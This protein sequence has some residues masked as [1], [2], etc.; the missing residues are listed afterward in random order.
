MKFLKNIILLLLF[1]AVV[2]AQ[3]KDLSF[4]IKKAKTNSPLLFKQKTQNKILAVEAN[5]LKA[6]Y[7]QP[8]IGL[9]AGILFAPIVS[10]DNNATKF[11]WISK[12][13]NDY[14]GYDL[15][16]SDGGQYQALVSYEQPLFS[17]KKLEI[18]NRHLMENIEKNQNDIQLT[19]IDIERFVGYQYLRCVQAKKQIAY[20]TDLQKLINDEIKTLNRLV[21]NGIYKPSDLQR[22]QIER[23]NYQIKISEAKINYEQNLYDLKI[24]CGINDTIIYDLQ[25]TEFQMQ[26]VAADTSVFFEKY[27]I[28]SLNLWTAQQVSELKYK[29]R[30]SAFADGG[31][32][33]VYL[34]GINRL[35]VSVGLK[36]SWV[37]Y[38][39]HQRNLEREKTNLLLQDVSFKKQQ[40]VTQ[41]TV[42]LSKLRSQMLNIDNQLKLKENQQNAYLKLL[43]IYKSELSQGNISIIDFSN[44]IRDMATVKQ[45]IILLEIKKKALINTYNYWNK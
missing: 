40:F 45:E 10:N 30:M 4:F 26:P 18:V 34:P 23:T 22:L 43:E 32:N 16:V 12:D 20:F 33:A 17:G 41:R 38:D 14:Y 37:L 39:G 24:L 21:Q 15:A 19:T 31:L 8:E 5:R 29:P 13:A 7:T 42:Q 44:T 9:N 2:S 35:G 3:P 1:P 28:D 25:D 11:Q 27:R 6:F 36:F